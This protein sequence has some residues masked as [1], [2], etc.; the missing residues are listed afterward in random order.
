MST[1]EQNKAIVTDVAVRRDDFSAFVDATTVRASVLV[2][3]NDHVRLHGAYGE[4][5]LG[6]ELVEAALVGPRARRMTKAARGMMIS[7]IR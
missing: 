2:R 6:G 4:G 1:I 7:R 5:M 3:L